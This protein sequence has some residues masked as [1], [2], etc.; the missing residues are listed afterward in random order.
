MKKNLSLIAVA[1]GVLTLVSC[2]KDYNCVC[3]Y[4]EGIIGIY[5]TVSQTSYVINGKADEAA[6]KCETYE[7]PVVYEDEFNYYSHRT[8][9][10]IK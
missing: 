4:Q 5:D 1:A 2:T 6:D 3:E 10:T 8:E 9:C 7:Q